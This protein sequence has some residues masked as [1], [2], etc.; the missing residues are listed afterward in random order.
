LDN[1]GRKSRS[2]KNEKLENFLTDL[3]RLT[4][5]HETDKDG[6][7]SYRFSN[8]A[9]KGEEEGQQESKPKKDEGKGNGKVN[10]KGKDKN[11]EQSDKQGS[12]SKDQNARS[13]EGGKAPE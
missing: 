7:A 4:L 9:D 1:I 11:E 6:R 5:V 8:E 3:Q 2:N 13:A 10:D 12:K